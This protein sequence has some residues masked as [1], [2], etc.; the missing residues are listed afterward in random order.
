MSSRAAWLV[1]VLLAG[2]SARAS[3][4][5]DVTALLK[6]IAAAHLEPERAVAVGRFSLDLGAGKLKIEK[7]TF[8]PASAIGGRTVEMVF[9]GEARLQIEP[10]DEIEKGQLDLYGG[11]RS[12]DEPVNEAVFVMAF[13]RAA[14]AVFKRPAV[15]PSPEDT[16][17]AQEIY[18]NWHSGAERRLLNVDAA[19]LQDALGDTLYQRYFAGR[20]HGTELGNL[21]FFIE[22]DAR[23][24]VTLGQFVP[25]DLT[26]REKRKATAQ[27][28]RLQR[29]GRLLG[30]TTE[31]LG[32]WTTW[33]S[34]PLRSSAGQPVPG[35]V[36]F[37][38]ERYILE[39]EIENRDLRLV[40]KA[41][42]QLKALT[43]STR[44][45]RLKLHSDLHV[46]R[47]VGG[48]GEELP[49]HQSGSEVMAV[50]AQAP[51]A[52]SSVTIE[53]EY[54]G[55]MIEKIDG[56]RYVLND[57]LAWYPHAGEVDRAPYEVTL[58]WPDRLDL[59][60]AGR[61]VDGGRA[62]DGSR[63]E[64][65][66]IDL[67]TA[68]FSF[69]IGR[70]AEA[71]RQVG[72]VQ[73]RLFTP[74]VG[75]GEK[76]ELQEQLLTGAADAV[77]FFE[78]VFGPY[79]LDELTLVMT[80]RS[81]SQAL[82]GFVT[83]SEL[84]MRG[85]GFVALLFNLEDPR[86]V[87]AHEIAHQWWGHQ[88]GW[89]SYRD[90]WISEA[91]ANYSAVLFARRKLERKVRFGIGPTTGWQSALMRRTDDGRPYESIGPLVLGARLASS[92]AG[93]AYGAIVYQKGAVV[94]DMLARH[95]GEEA[96][97]E[98]LR[99]VPSLVAHRAIST[100]GFFE[101]LERFSG[102]DLDFFTHQYVF[103]TGLPEVYYRYT[104][105][106]TESG[107]W[108]VLAQARQI[109]PY[110]HRYRLHQL[111]E[112]G[113][114]DVARDTLQQLD[115]SRSELIVPLEI[116]VFD[117]KVELTAEERKDR[118][119]ERRRRELGNK[120]VQGRFWLR[121]ETG[122]ID[123][124]LDFEPRDLLLDR[125]QEVFGRF[126]NERHRPK[127]T[128]Y[129]RALDAVA[130]GDAAAAEASCRQALAVAV[131]E[132]PEYDDAPDEDSQ[133]EDRKILDGQVQLLL[134]RL[135]LD[136][137][138]D[139]EAATAIEAAR[140]LLRPSARP[141]WEEPLRILDARLALHQRDAERAY[142]RLKKKILKTGD[143]EDAEG[144]LLLAI[145]ATE[146]GKEKE[147][148]DALEI[149]KELGADTS[150]L[151]KEGRE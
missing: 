125:R 32:E 128:Q 136:A 26:A 11:T 4:D 103:G 74:P 150:L 20:F 29:R 55:A 70:F 105:Q 92:R 101:I 21:L 89:E 33:L 118:K 84:M 80:P 138:R 31:D 132:G 45:V 34:T 130:A 10:P 83:L 39:V 109:S 104:F 112:S 142:K 91:M 116:T 64:K 3:A 60:A 66:S 114:Y 50:L 14:E 5:S 1:L 100:E 38:P 139:D 124:E 148:R 87:I 115:V 69:E 7:G 79:P 37:E 149:A 93:G 144:A 12:L 67:P 133:A 49:F 86:T 22:P 131:Y 85:E 111:A 71:T 16:T 135:F 94:F 120:T 78:E 68:G 40:G 13:D 61:H 9:L 62:S 42:L 147:A 57:T 44:A 90:Q 99:R 129:L 108:R 134:A 107:K 77:A 18:R 76:K 81:F 8:F 41:R 46:S 65:R 25:L 98:L 146:L 113:R 141:W 117:P 123:I 95:F 15:A 47:V 23:E 52:D 27:L 51:A 106:P 58:R 73:I 145:A 102:A 140:D 54:S 137:G 122:E 48:A 96:F 36:G 53:V 59:A 75:W 30:L 110:R 88:V 43:G 126:F 63:W 56:P 35:L 19:L 6:E 72:H 151:E 24:Q 2:A 82:L 17:R 119:A 97:I 143:L 121:G 28:D 127:R